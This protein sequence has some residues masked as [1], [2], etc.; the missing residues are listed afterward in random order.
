MAEA[1]VGLRL[2]LKDRQ[3]VARGLRET[4][5]Q[6]E[7][8]ADAGVKVEKSTGRS[9]GALSKLAKGG[10]GALKAGAIG[11]AGAV[12]GLGATALW[13]G[14]SR[15]QGIDQAKSKLT[16]L[17]HSAQGVDKIMGN[18]LA[19]VEGTAFGLDAAATTAAGAVAAGVK[20][21]KDLERTLSLVGD[22]ATIAGT[23]MDSMGSIFNKV[24]ASDMI[25]GD[26]IAQLQDAGIPVLQLLSKE[27][28]VSANEV[29][30]LASSGKVD[31]ETFQ[32]AMES[33]LGGAA[34]ESGKTFSG[35]MAN[36]QAALGR[37]GAKLLE[38]VF[39]Q[40]PGMMQG[41]T[42]AIDKLG[43]AAT[44]A[45]QWL[46]QAF[47]SIGPLVSQVAGYFSGGGGSGLVSGL[48]DFAGT[49]V[50]T[51]APVVGNLV[52]LFRT[53]V[54]PA[55]SAVAGFFTQK[56][57]PVV[58]DIAGVFRNQ[59]LP[60]WGQVAGFISG[61]LLPMLLGIYA[62][63]AVKL[64]PIFEQL[65]STFRTQ[66]LPTVVVLLEKFR[67]WWPTIQRVI[68]VVVTLV[69]KLF[70]FCAT[71]LGKVLPVVIRLAG[72]FISNVVPAI[73][74]VI[75][76][77]VKIIGKAFDF[78]G[79][80]R[81]AIGWAAN[82][83]S[84]MRDKVAGGVESVVSAVASLPG[85]IMALGGR[86]ASA[87]RSII[88]QFVDGLK[89]A[90]SLVADIAGN[91]WDAVRGLLNSAISRINASLEFTIN[92]P[93]PD[94]HINP[95]DIPHLASGGP[96]AA[97]QPYVVGD[98]GR[99]E[100]FVPRTDGQILPR[101]PSWFDDD[102]AVLTASGGGSGGSLVVQVVMPDSRVLAEVVMDE[103]D[104][105]AALA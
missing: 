79:A 33:G 90:G 76:W 29:R 85:K 39:T 57:I 82:F 104:D 81:N 35:S 91:I 45:G 32:S 70:G 93:G 18:A 75:G 59:V 66:V 62:N 97:G 51:V 102:D 30:N 28:G 105:L 83:A 6:L 100:L 84:T 49:V 72:F 68:S 17:G 16:G 22:A 64:K 11:A 15:L 67:E 103:L 12:A 58:T 95:P 34:L 43:P 26:V 37:L 42:A 101:V 63:I 4:A 87:G 44:K 60:V 50:A 52:T 3:T 56:L 89:N 38:G 25:Q 88:G 2:A 23:D 5:D 86:M 94:V 14:F 77:V 69:G 96:V 13:K 19:S 40:I 78:V 31:F 1:E 24:A 71:V 20:P 27:L 21:G 55:V 61:K 9:G 8:V 41:A 98:G 47:A 73:A 10:L 48:R 74:T 36:A 65:V 7:G 92:L 99:P 54:L 46:G 53:Q 80:I